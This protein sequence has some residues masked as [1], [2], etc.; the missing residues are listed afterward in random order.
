MN[1]FMEYEYNYKNSWKFICLH[2]VDFK[3]N[4]NVFGSIITVFV[5]DLIVAI[6]LHVQ[7]LLLTNV[8][9]C[10]SSNLGHLNIREFIVV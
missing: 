4:T 3:K 10:L 7:T 6:A 1:V 2:F 9:Y 8:H 5:Y